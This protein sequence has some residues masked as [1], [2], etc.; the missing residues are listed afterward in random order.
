MAQPLAIDDTAPVCRCVMVC[1][2]GLIWRN[3][4]SIK[5]LQRGLR[6]DQIRQAEP[7]LNNHQQ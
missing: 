2:V 1:I 3:L 5:L 4:A 7:E 6:V